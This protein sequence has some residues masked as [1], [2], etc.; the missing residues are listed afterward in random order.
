MLPVAD[1]PVALVSSGVVAFAP[2]KT[3]IFSRVKFVAPEKVAVPD[4]SDGRTA[5]VGEIRSHLNRGPVDGIRNRD[6]PARSAYPDG[7][8]GPGRNTRIST[9]N[10]CNA[11]TTVIAGADVGDTAWGRR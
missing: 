3:M 8:D 4:I 11:A 1:D 9:G 2:E 7:D 10:G 6:G 5:V